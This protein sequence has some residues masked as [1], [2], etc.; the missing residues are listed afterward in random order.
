MNDND[1]RSRRDRPR[2]VEQAR[3]ERAVAGRR[4]GGVSHL[5]L[6]ASPPSVVSRRAAEEEELRALIRALGERSGGIAG[7]NRRPGDATDDGG[8][9]SP[10]TYPPAA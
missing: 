9:D 2:L 7:R 8:G 4:G 6:L 1:S 10:D 3:P 5:R